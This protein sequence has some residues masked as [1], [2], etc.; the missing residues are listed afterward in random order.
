MSSTTLITDVVAI[1]GVL[2]VGSALGQYVGSS[3]DRR[4]A[5]AGVLSALA[6]TESGRW[7]NLDANP[8]GAEF[9]VS[10]RKLQTAALIA[11]LPRDAVWEYG[12]LAQAARWQSQQQWD[13][14]DDKDPETGGGIDAH[15]SGAVREAAR[16]IAVL[17]WSWVPLHIWRWRLAKKRINEHL[18]KL[19][20]PGTKDAVM[21]SRDHGFM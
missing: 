7:A 9:Q 6:E 14:D 13:D 10:M 3:K 8:G 11:R 2:G 17:A 16:A 15:L 4:E 18:A 19:Q 20:G 12:V 1:L 5:R 21:R